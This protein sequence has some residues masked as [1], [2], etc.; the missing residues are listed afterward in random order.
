MRILPRNWS[1]RNYIYRNLVLITLFSLCSIVFLTGSGPVSDKPAATGQGSDK[2]SPAVVA[3]MPLW[4]VEQDKSRLGFIGDY[5]GTEFR[6][7]FKKFSAIIRFDPEHPES[8]HFDVTIDTTSVTTYNDDWDDVISY[9]EW[10]N[11]KEYPVSKYVTHSISTLDDDKYLAVGTLDLKGRQR[12]VELRF[13]WT[14]L[15]SGEVSIKGQARMVGHAEVDRTEFGIGEGKW[16]EDDTVAFKIQVEVNLL[17]S[18][19]K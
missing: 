1:P 11:S 16:E 2:Q 15:A 4:N 18:P 8:G 14:T 17:L 13:T 19:D 5:A 3:A 12:D 10:F 6:G 7:E 9:Q